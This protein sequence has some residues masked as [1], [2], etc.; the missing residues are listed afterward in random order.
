MSLQRHLNEPF[1]ATAIDRMDSSVAGIV[2]GLDRLVK[3]S[4]VLNHLMW[5]GS[6]WRPNS[7][8][9]SSGCAIDYIVVEVGRRP[10]A[11]E[12]SAVMRFINEVL[13]AN[14]R[15]LGIR[16]ILFSTDGKNRTQSWNPLRGYWK[17][18]DPRGGVSADHVDHVHIL[19][20]A[21]ASWPA[22]LD[23][24]V[25]G[26]APV[27]VPK[28][29]P[30]LPG[31]GA[32]GPTNPAPWDGKT[33]PGVAAFKSGQKHA[34]VKVVQER[35]KVHGYDP[36]VVDSYWGPVSTAATRRFQLAQGW[37]GS[38]ADGVPGPKT[39]ERLLA[40]PKQAQKSVAQMA[41][42]V[43][44]GKHGSGHDTRRRSLGISEALYQQVRAE[45]N[46]RVSGKPRGKSIA[47]MATEVIEGKHGT[48]HANRQRSLGIDAATY[49]KVR[50]E[51][52]RRV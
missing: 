43:I 32:E 12:R 31:T 20:H 41:Q 7:T 51:V 19:F 44:D 36:G 23:K 29:T 27:A 42:E 15:A 24:L 28:P 21:S 22:Y 18:L 38:G 17:N 6:G 39:W 34:A 47:Q 52:N 35:L 2:R 37:T 3:R 10:T 49:R 5:P 14:W 4:P 45:V 30:G 8:E 9:H 48:G 25:I 40:A 26:S 16:W 11:D 46:R 13:I 1:Y 33:F 50:A